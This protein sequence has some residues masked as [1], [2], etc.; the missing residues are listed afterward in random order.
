VVG[1][2]VDTVIGAVGGDARIGSAY[3]KPGW[4]PAGPCL[5]RDLSVWCS[6][7]GSYAPIARE[8]Y[9]GHI[10]T[11]NRIV[12][13]V[14]EWIK[15]CEGV[16]S[17]KTPI[18]GVL[19]LVYNPGAADGTLSQGTAIVDAC[20]GRGWSALGYDPMGGDMV[21]GVSS[22]S[23]SLILQEVLEKADVL[24]VA[25]PWPEFDTLNWTSGVKP[26]LRLGGAV[27]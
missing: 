10:K 1:A 25:T 7:G 26:V 18:V 19:G 14:V 9:Y 6:L 3:L 16:W 17:G 22:Y 23:G 13:S 2:S 11:R 8:I 21:S 12:E 15:T 20:I 27:R 5:P 24:I 4:S